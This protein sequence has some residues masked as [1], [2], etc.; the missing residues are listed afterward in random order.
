MQ[1]DT[2]LPDQA[3]TDASSVIFSTSL[4]SPDAIFI[5]GTMIPKTTGPRPGSP[6]ERILDPISPDA[7]T[8]WDIPECSQTTAGYIPKRT[9]MF[10]LADLMKSGRLPYPITQ[11]TSAV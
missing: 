11:T 6:W 8:A 7:A 1:E 9:T 10:R 2:A 3:R 5:S 4:T